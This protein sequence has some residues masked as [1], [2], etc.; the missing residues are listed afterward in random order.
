M[1]GD[2]RIGWNVV[3]ERLCAVHDD[4]GTYA[5][6]EISFPESGRRELPGGTRLILGPTLEQIRAAFEEHPIADGAPEAGQ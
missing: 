3:T 5:A 6:V 4:D 1:S 2:I